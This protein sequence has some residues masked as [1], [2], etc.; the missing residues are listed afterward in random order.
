MLSFLLLL[1]FCFFPRFSNF[2]NL[3]I[4]SAILFVLFHLNL[5]FTHHLSFAGKLKVGVKSNFQLQWLTSDSC[6][7]K[8]KTVKGMEVFPLFNRFPHFLPSLLFRCQFSFIFWH[9]NKL[10]SSF[11]YF[12]VILLPL[13]LSFFFDGKSILETCAQ[14]LV[15]YQALSFRQQINICFVAVFLLEFSNQTHTHTLT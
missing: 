14:I 11:A 8:P 12:S 4:Y 7:G 15:L 13:F 10:S 5:T 6:R 1:L 3:F 9:V 2:T